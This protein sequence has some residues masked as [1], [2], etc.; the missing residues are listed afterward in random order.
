M[1]WAVLLIVALALAPFPSIAAEIPSGTCGEG[2]Q[3]SLSGGVLTV[4][5][6]GEMT[7]YTEFDPGPW[8]EF[9][10]DIRSVIISYGVTP[11]GDLAFD[12]C[13]SL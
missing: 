13:Q 4:S 2:L 12:D 3:W 8:W 11:V 10:Q 7:D 5:G 9:R 1:T 6:T